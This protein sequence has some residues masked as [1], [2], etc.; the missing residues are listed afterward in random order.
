LHRYSRLH[1]NSADWLAHTRGLPPRPHPVDQ[2]SDAR[3]QQSQ[4]QPA[5]HH[6]S[7]DEHRAGNVRCGRREGLSQPSED[8]ECPE[9]SEDDHRDGSPPAPTAG[10]QGEHGKGDPREEWQRGHRAVGDEFPRRDVRVARAAAELSGPLKDERE[11]RP[12]TE[13]MKIRTQTEKS[14]CV[15]RLT[16][17]PPS[18]QFL[19]TR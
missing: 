6:A 8:E 3:Q 9:K 10:Q 4:A 11:E 12:T 5:V 18:N 1:K 13:A 2:I 14:L 17:A 15:V 16:A 19:P 7:R